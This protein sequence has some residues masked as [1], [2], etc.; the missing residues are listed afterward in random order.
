MLLALAA[1]VVVVVGRSRLPFR[2]VGRAG[3][4]LH[5]VQHAAGRDAWD[6]KGE[7]GQ[8]I[9]KKQWQT[10]LAEHQGG[11]Q[12]AAVEQQALALRRRVLGDE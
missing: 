2:L 1:L 5:H 6:K 4:F 10:L 12:H 8:Q 7:W 11:I 3:L 9:G